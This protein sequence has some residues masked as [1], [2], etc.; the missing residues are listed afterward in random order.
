MEYANTGGNIPSIRKDFNSTVSMGLDKL[1]TSKG[2]K[3]KGKSEL[4]GFT[5]FAFKRGYGYTSPFWLAHIIK[6]LSWPGRGLN[7]PLVPVLRCFGFGFWVGSGIIKVTK[8][9]F[10]VQRNRHRNRN[11]TWSFC[12]YDWDSPLLWE[13]GDRLPWS[14]LPYLGKTTQ[15]WAVSTLR[16]VQSTRE[17]THLPW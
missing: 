2:S 8:L 14:Y 9:I 12:F 17:K 5:C 6:S 11:G 16:R 4:A 10:S 15:R 7:F 3:K 1:A 13:R